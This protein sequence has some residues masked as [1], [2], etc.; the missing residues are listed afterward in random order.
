M[1]PS[2]L[3]E[4]TLDREALINAIYSLQATMQMYV[5]LLT[6]QRD[7]VIHPATIGTLQYVDSLI[8]EGQR[9]RVH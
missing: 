1:I 8:R 7:P 2:T 4:P 9:F 5:E 3:D 6:R